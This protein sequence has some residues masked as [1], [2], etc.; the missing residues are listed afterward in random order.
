[1]TLDGKVAT[2]TGDSKWISGEDSRRLSHHWRAECDAV[3]VGIGTA[4][5]DDPQL[6]ARDRRRRPASRAGSSSTPRRACRWTRSSCAARPSVPLTVVTSRAA[7]RLAAD[8]L[9]VAGAEVI[10]ATGRERARRAC[11]T[12]STSSARPASRRSCSRA[13]RT[14]RARSWTPARSTRS[15]CSSRRSCSAGRSARD[16]LEGEGAERIAD[17][18]RALHAGVRARR[19][20]R[21]DHRPHAGVVS[22][23]SPGWS[24][25]LGHGRPPSTRRRTACVCAVRTTSAPE[26]CRG[27]LGRGQ[28]RLPD[29]DRG[30]RRRASR[31]T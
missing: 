18:M 24:Q 9:E 17:A 27:R 3:A 11:A 5:T 4:L 14:W 22:A 6:T 26:I 15:A 29:R 13:A 16:P 2:R 31:P 25:D 28:R 20:R 12:R 10:V 19:R 7:P 1:M 21:A 30:R 8:A 23:C